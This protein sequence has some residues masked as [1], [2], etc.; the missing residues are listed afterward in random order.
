MATLQ[1]ELSE[2]IGT[3]RDRRSRRDRGRENLRPV[4]V[5]DNNPVDQK[6]N[7]DELG[8]AWPF[9]RVLE[10]DFAAESEEALVKLRTKCFALAVLDWELPLLRKC[11]VL[12]HLRQHGVRIPVVVIFRCGARGDQRRSR[13]TTGSLSEQKAG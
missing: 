4:L 8:Q 2:C 7:D 1:T 3:R 9:E 13:C 5:V 12:R 10:L 11:E 6:Y